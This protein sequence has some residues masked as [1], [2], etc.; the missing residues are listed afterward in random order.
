MDSD[1][2]VFHMPAIIGYNV[3]EM[4]SKILYDQLK[5]PNIYVD[6]DFLNGSFQLNNGFVVISVHIAFNIASQNSY[7]CSDRENRIEK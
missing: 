5:C 3:L 7:I 1:Y 4:I 2:N 6:N